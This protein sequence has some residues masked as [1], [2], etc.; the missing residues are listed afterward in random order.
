MGL[1]LNIDYLKELIYLRNIYS[2]SMDKKLQI[3]KSIK[4]IKNISFRQIH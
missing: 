1:G 2:K 4:K 3:E